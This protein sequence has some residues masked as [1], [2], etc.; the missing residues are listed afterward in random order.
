[1]STLSAP[2]G[3]A[4]Y[5]LTLDCPDSPGLVH[6]ISGVLLKHGADIIDNRQFSD[7]LHQQAAADWTSRTGTSSCACI[8]APRAGQKRWPAFILTL[9]RWPSGTACGGNCAR[10]GKSGV[11]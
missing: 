4:Q 3:T 10:T 7:R 8:S 9:S 11:C 6:Q 5:V 1:M 2:A